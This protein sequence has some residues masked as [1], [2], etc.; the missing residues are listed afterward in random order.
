MRNL[1]WKTLAAVATLVTLA[2]AAGAQVTTGAIAGLVS[3]GRG[4]PVDNVQIQLTNLENGFKARGLTRENGRY[5]IPNLDVG[6]GYSVTIRRIGFAT[7]RSDNIVV[8]LGQ[9]TQVNFQLVA[10]AANLEAVTVTAQERS[11]G[12]SSSRTGVES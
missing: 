4:K 2:A 8:T 1:R 3:D 11:T 9:T 10:Q 6:A 7:Q 5:T 12:F